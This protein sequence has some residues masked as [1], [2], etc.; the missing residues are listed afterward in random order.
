[1]RK[2]IF[3]SLTLVLLL[4]GTMPALMAQS[5]AGTILGTVTDTTGGV[6]PGV[7]VSITK[8]D[9]GQTRLAITGD[10]GRYTA[11]Q[12]AVGIYEVRAELSGFQ[13]SVQPSVALQIG[14][15]ALVNL[16]LEIGSIS[17]EVIVSSEAPLVNTTSGTISAVISEVQVHELP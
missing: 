12:L 10:E 9:T 15:E 17:E 13:T 3:L 2:N 6:L 4:S 8:I 5:S 14:Q 11:P 1:M 7:E 16:T